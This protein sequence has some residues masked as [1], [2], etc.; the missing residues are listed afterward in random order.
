MTISSE[1]WMNSKYITVDEKGWHCSDDAPEE[2][3]K[4][5]KEFMKMADNPIV[6]EGV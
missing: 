6:V 5:F 1:D 4:A 2:I 3:K